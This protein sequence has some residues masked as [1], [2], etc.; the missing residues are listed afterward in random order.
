MDIAY[1]LFLQN[2]RENYVPFLIPFMEAVSLFDITFILFI[3]AYVYW[4]KDKRAGR[5]ILTTWS[6]AVAINSV[7]KL[8]CCIYRPWIRDP[9][10]LPAGDAIT[11]ATGYSFPSGHSVYASTLY[12]SAAFHYHRKG[13][14]ILTGFYIFMALLTG[15]SRNFLGVHTPQ[16]VFVGLTEGFVMIFLMHK[17][18]SRIEEHPEHLNK[19][20]IGG[21]A[22][23]VLGLIYIMVKPYP[24]T[25]VDGALLVD[26]VKMRY[27]G[28]YDINV[29]IAV[30]IA[31]YVDRT[32]INYE[33]VPMKG[34]SLVVAIAGGLGMFVMIAFLWPYCMRDADPVL[35][36]IGYAYLFIFYIMLIVP[37]ILKKSAEQKAEG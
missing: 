8:T 30:L 31:V 37:F 20:V 26:P 17:A 16:D 32:W 36:R 27:D 7:V 10:V 3:P 28:I 2:I 6:V 33:P 21:I 23:A 22:L 1:L 13:V 25:Y 29:M 19:Y 18:Y 34:R 4:C 9:R 12:G 14:K 15:F 11:T 35:G 24:V 5:H